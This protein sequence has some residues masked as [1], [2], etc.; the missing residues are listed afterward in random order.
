MKKFALVFLAAGFTALTSCQNNVSEHETAETT[1]TEN[2]ATEEV[3][4]MDSAA[5]MQAWMEY[6]T[7]GDMHNMLASF[8]G[9]WEGA[10]T[11]WMGPDAPPETNTGTS[12]NKMIFDGRYQESVYKGDFGG[13]PFEGRS[14][15]AY[16]N[17]KKMFLSTW[18]DNMGTGIMYMEGPWDEATKTMNLKGKMVDPMSAGKEI[19]VRETLQIIDE[20]T[21]KMEMFHTKNGK[22]FKAMEIMYKRKK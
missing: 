14:I 3:P 19:D 4:T 17:A 16:D 18:I 1:T 11:M 7:P 5:A 15:T 9:K 12:E 6:M 22:E 13:M 21:Q 20:N 2:A 10:I 8:N